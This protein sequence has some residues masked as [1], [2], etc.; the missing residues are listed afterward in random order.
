MI[1]S[2]SVTFVLSATCMIIAIVLAAIQ[3]ETRLGYSFY[4]A[5][6]SVVVTGLIDFAAFYEKVTI[7]G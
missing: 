6:S 1:S 7:D 3:Q 5:V 4:L 2:I